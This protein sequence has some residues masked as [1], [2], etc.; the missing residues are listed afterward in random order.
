MDS[1]TF[2]AAGESYSVCYTARARYLFEQ[3][4]GYPLHKIGAASGKISDVELPIL[5]LAGLEGHRCRTKAR[6]AAWTLDEVL[7]SVLGD[8]GAAEGVRV[9]TECMA[10]VDLAFRAA[11]K[12]EAAEGAE[13]KAATTA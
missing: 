4:A 1:V 6:K 2:T 13:G 10:A 5:V 9:L 12:A 7:D 3:L 11:G 8:L